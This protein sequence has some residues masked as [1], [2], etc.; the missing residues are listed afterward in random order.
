M[1][2]RRGHE[3]LTKN[4]A[5]LIQR[6]D[7]VFLQGAF[8]KNRESTLRSKELLLSDA[9]SEDLDCLERV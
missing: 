1:S 7:V 9:P 2:R 5:P 4:H 8:L 6:M 3:C